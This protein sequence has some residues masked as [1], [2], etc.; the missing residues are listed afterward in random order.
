VLA[1]RAALR[2]E[3]GRTSLLVVRDG[4]VQGV[5]VE[6]GAVAEED[7]EIRGPVEPGEPAVVGEN[8]GAVAPGVRVRIVRAE[9]PV[10]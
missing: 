7:A 6:V 4:R 1:P 9:A 3:D 10:S 5:P 8:G 2:L